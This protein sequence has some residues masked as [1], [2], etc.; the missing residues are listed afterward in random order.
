[1]STQ[2]TVTPS[3]EVFRRAA[4]LARLTHRDVEEVLAETLELSLAPVAPDDVSL[5]SVTTLSDEEVLALANGRMEAAQD[6]RLQALQRRLG[7]GVLRDDER[8][9]LQALMQVYQNGLLRKAQALHEAVR[10]GLVEK[11]AS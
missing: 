9:E 6:R 8:T 10:R 11:A 2:I 4:D 1:M 5:P 3:D 7:A